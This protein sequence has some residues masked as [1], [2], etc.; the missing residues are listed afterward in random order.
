[1]D[2]GIMATLVS[3]LV[4]AAILVCI[5]E[6]VLTYVLVK[7]G[8]AEVNPVLRSLIAKLGLSRA[9]ALSRLMMIPLLIIA[10]WWDNVILAVFALAAPSVAVLYY[11][12]HR[13][14]SPF[15]KPS[16]VM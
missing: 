13:Y 14:D 11:F 5:L 7:R 3:I 10:V 15:R 12:S 6:R 2:V 4:S 9:I 8:V 16:K 1:M